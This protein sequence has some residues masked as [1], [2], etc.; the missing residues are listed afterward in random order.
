MRC[1]HCER[2]IV[3]NGI[4]VSADGDFV[5]SEACRVEFEREKQHFSDVLIHDPVAMERWL[6]GTS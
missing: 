6:L 2:E 5:C 4:L 1:F 3:G